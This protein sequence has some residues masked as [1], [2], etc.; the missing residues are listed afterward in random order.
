MRFY[1]YNTEKTVEV[2][3][4]ILK[5]VL[6]NDGNG[7]E[8][9][10]TDNGVYSTKAYYQKIFDVT[11]RAN[12]GKIIILKHIIRIDIK[13]QKAYKNYYYLPSDDILE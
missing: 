2:N 7:F 13:N 1:D 10:H 6:V 8:P 3:G 11:F 9:F 4:E 12:D 5:E